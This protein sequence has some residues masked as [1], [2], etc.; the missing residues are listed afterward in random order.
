[1]PQQTF[2]SYRLYQCALEKYLKDLFGIVIP[3]VQRAGEYVFNIPRALTPAE[4]KYI[5]DCL[6]Y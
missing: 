5:M 2:D 1:M 4:R 3:C 6:R